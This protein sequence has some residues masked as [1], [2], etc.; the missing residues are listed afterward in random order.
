MPSASHPGSGT[1]GRHTRYSQSAR[2]RPRFGKHD[3][4]FEKSGTSDLERRLIALEQY[5]LLLV[6]A[7]VL[8]LLAYLAADRRNGADTGSNSRPD[9]SSASRASTNLTSDTLR[10]LHSHSTSLASTPER[11]RSAPTPAALPALRP[12]PL[13]APQAGLRR[14]ISPRQQCDGASPSHQSHHQRR[15][16]IDLPILAL[17][18]AYASNGPGS[19]AASTH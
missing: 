3:S 19:T 13:C 14:S 16:A 4:I 11:R 6:L 9:L 1:T 5:I 15:A 7:A 12:A 10:G 8:V 18:C 2:Y 17:T